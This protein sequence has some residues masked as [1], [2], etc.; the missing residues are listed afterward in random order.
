MLPNILGLENFSSLVEALPMP[1]AIYSGDD[2]IISIANQ[3][4]L[5]LWGKDQTVIGRALL[6]G[7]PEL[8]GQPFFDILTE[9]YRTGITYQAKEDKAYL[10]VNG[11]LQC[12]YFTFTYKAVKDANGKIVGIFNTAADVTELVTARK[13]VSDT[14][15]RLS[16]A[17]SSAEVG[18]WDL[19]PI[20][21]HVEWDVRCKELFGFSGSAAVLYPDV[22]SC[23]HPDDEERVHGAVKD[24][25]KPESLG[26]YN[27]KYR[28]INSTTQQLRWVHCK[29][30]AYFNEQNIAH[31]F[32]GT[33]L[34][35]T[36]EVGSRTRELQLLS[37]VEH[38]IDHM[39]IADMEG[40]LIYMNRAARNLLGVPKKH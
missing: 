35:I 40:N 1:T 9:V 26:I 31:R 6:E 18:T 14:Q 23:I 25:L 21:N 19:D 12:F 3:A 13:M 17:L 27:I 16:F 38:N 24:A 4:M 5:E 22:M 39:S 36:A 37:L 8:V 32:A 29:G 28:T 33:A 10:V 2:M 15:H 20:N 7:I 11:S 34:D 30:K